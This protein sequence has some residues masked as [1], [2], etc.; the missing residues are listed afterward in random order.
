MTPPEELPAEPVNWEPEHRALML[1]TLIGEAG[2]ALADIT[3][4]LKDTYAFPRTVPF[5]SPLDGA[6]LGYVQRARSE[7]QW[8]VTSRE[9]VQE[10]FTREF[11]AVL[12]AVFLLNIP[13][14]DEPVALPEDHPIT[15]ALAGSAP[16][17][18][19]PTQQVPPQVI[20][21]A[22]QDARDNGQSD[23]PGIQLVRKVGNLNVVYDKK[24]GPAAIGRLVRTGL[25]DWSQLGIQL[26]TGRPAL[27]A[28]DQAE[29]S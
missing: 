4:G 9:Q 11:P 6:A 14:R 1:Q 26:G 5:E 28:G 15:V 8:V 19:T 16:E 23:V 24:S 7:P 29:A 20:E 22:L 2:K 12:E 3:K 10:Y 17:L 18:L 13:G 25:L 27:P 21:D